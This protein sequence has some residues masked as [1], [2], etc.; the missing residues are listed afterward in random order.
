MYV[1]IYILVMLEKNCNQFLE[2]YRSQDKSKEEDNNIKLQCISIKLKKIFTVL[3][4][5]ESCPKFYYYLSELSSD[6]YNN[7]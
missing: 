3:K 1:Y 4:R 6:L 2:T 7:I 5:S